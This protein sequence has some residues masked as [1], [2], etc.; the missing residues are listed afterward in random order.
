MP[1]HIM[2]RYCKFVPFRL[3]RRDT[4]P[5]SK[6]WVMLIAICQ[7]ETRVKIYAVLL[8]AMRQLLLS[9]LLKLAHTTM[10]VRRIAWALLIPIYQQEIEQRIY[11]VPSD[12]T[13][14]PSPSI[15]LRLHHRN[16][17]LCRIIRVQ[18]IL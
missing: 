18:H 12:V 5:H 9:T 4:L 10:L 3:L 15:L 2:N 6:T 11:A 8:S 7:Q 1:F 17:P 16:M 13:K 14:Q